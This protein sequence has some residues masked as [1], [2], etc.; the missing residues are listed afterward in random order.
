MPEAATTGRMVVRSLHRHCCCL[1]LG[2]MPKISKSK[3]ILHDSKRAPRNEEKSFVD[4]IIRWI[5]VAA[6][7]MIVAIISCYLPGGGGGSS[8][9]FLLFSYYQSSSRVA[10][11][12]ATSRQVHGRQTLW[13]HHSIRF[14]RLLTFQPAGSIAITTLKET[15]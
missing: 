6:D 10:A 15:A 7:V 4:S 5:H 1:V 11:A 3:K 9:C 12:A 2:A 8:F 13:T 14:R